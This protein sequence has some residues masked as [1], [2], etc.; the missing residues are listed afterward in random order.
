[1][2]D[3]HRGARLAGFADDT[4]INGPPEMIYHA[5]AE[6]RQVCLGP[7]G[8]GEPAACELSSNLSKVY[9]TSPAGSIADI[10]EG[11]C[12]GIKWADGYSCVGIFHGPDEWVQA[13]LEEKLLKRLGPLDGLDQLEDDELFTNVAQMKKILITDCVALQGV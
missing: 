4:Y 12:A 9:A 1:M 2:Q 7:A 11:M 3:K 6:K 13:K 8:P 10:P 5:Y